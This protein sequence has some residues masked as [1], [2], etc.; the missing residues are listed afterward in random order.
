MSEIQNLQGRLEQCRRDK[1]AIEKEERELLAAIERNKTVPIVAFVTYLMPDD[2]ILINLSDQA[3]EYI[4]AGA[5]QVVF[6]KLG[7]LGDHRRDYGL[8]D[9]YFNLKPIFGALKQSD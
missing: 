7:C 8:T 5:K 1:A 6:D 4:K 9:V 2:R 3:I